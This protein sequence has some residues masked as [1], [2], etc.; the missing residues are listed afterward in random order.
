MINRKHILKTA[1][2]VLALN[3]N[4]GNASGPCDED[5]SAK[6]GHNN[7]TVG[8]LLRQGMLDGGSCTNAL[9]SVVNDINK[10]KSCAR[11]HPDV[12][13]NGNGGDFFRCATS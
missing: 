1:L 8:D 11:Q 9:L 13:V 3:I 7:G 6:L 2:L 5:L 4:I 10:W 12:L